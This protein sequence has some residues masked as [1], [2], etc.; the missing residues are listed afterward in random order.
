MDTQHKESYPVLISRKTNNSYHVKAVDFEDCEVFDSHLHNAINKIIEKIETLSWKISSDNGQIPTPTMF[1]DLESRIEESQTILFVDVAK[2]YSKLPQTLYLY[3]PINEHLLPMLLNPYVWFSDPAE[4]NDPFERPDVLKDDWS[5]EEIKREIEFVFSKDKKKNKEWTKNFENSAQIYNHIKNS[6]DEL[7]G[8]LGEKKRALDFVAS[9]FRT[10]CFSRNFDNTL[11]WSHYTDKHKGIV[12][13][14]DFEMIRAAG[15]GQIEGSDIDYR[16]HKDKL[17]EGSFAGDFDKKKALT[18]KYVI[19]KIF[20]KHPSW[21]Y[22]QEFRF[23]T[24][25]PGDEKNFSPKL[26]LPPNVI[27]ELYFG[28]RMPDETKEHVSYILKDK[29]VA[30][31][32][33]YLTENSELKHQQYVKTQNN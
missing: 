6:P 16:R 2:R 25:I 20:T 7:R 24:R 19:R 29:E 33:M 17:R 21:S 32:E 8:F 5:K 1:K 26:N 10:A 22:E 18:L 14:Y 15:K 4:Y 30:L 13:G 9:K 28:C 31:F 3:Y 11:M 23:I 12:I 27:K